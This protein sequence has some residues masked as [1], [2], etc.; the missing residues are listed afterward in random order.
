MEVMTFLLFIGFFFVGSFL[1]LFFWT[2]R[3]GSLQHADRLALLPLSS[4]DTISRSTGSEDKKGK[5]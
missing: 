3:K 4:E 5:S 2:I 1:W